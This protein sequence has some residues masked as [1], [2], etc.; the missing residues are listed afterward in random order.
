MKQP[1][2]ALL[3]DKDGTLVDFQLTWAGAYQ[4]AAEEVAAQYLTADMG[5]EAVSATDLL[6][7]GGM[8]ADTGRFPATSVMACG[9]TPEIADAWS[10]LLGGV[11][12]E[13]IAQML[14]RLFLAHAGERPQPVPKLT[15]TLDVLLERGFRLGVATMDSEAMAWR[16]LDRLNITDRFEFVCGFDTGYGHKP[17]PGMIRAFCRHTGLDASEVGMVGDS[18]HDL[19]M[20]QAAKAGLVVGVLT[21]TGMERDLAPIS[22]HV[23]P[24]IA[25]LPALLETL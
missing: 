24:G 9:T 18:P 11:A 13:P 4:V 6:L 14:E 16:N 22:D 1:I 23:L 7:C 20:G 3:F 8:D 17:G 25:S 21:G 2:K 12:A 5:C 10:R 19:L 15:E